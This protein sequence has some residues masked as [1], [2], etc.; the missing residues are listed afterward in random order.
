MHFVTGGAFN[1]KSAWVKSHYQNEQIEWLSAYEAETIPERMHADL[2]VLEGLELWIKT[3]IDDHFRVNF[4]KLLDDWKTWEQ[5]NEA[6][7]LI[8]IGTDIT[9]GIVPIDSMDREWRDAVGW[10]YQDLAACADR[11]DL[12]WYGLNKRL[13]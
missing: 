7:Q 5:G 3:L 10:A 9:K 4:R 12:V 2:I 13:K 11:V 8:I 6:R 1:G